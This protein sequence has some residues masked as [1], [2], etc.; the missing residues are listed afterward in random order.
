MKKEKIFPI[1]IKNVGVSINNKQE[2][3]NE[4]IIVNRNLKLQIEEKEKHAAELI[5]ANKELAFQNN[6]KEKRAAELVIANKELA[7][8]NDEKVKRAAELIVANIELAFQS[9]E[10]IKRTAELLIANKEL[11]SFTYISNHD[12]QEPL[13]KI[14]V[15]SS[16][17]IAEES[18]NLS[19][20]GLHYFERIQS[21]ALHMQTLIN[22]LLEYSRTKETKRKFEKVQL[23]K[24]VLDV[25]ES[26]KEKLEKKDAIVETSKLCEAYVIPFQF[27]Q[28]LH[29]LITNSL[30]FCLPD[31]QPHIIISSKYIYKKELVVK[32]ES[33]Q[34]EYCR[35]S[36]EDN[37][38]GFDPEFK[39]K[40]FDI[41]QRLHDPKIYEGTGIGLAIVKKIVDNHNG[42]ITAIGEVGKGATF[43]IYMP[44]DQD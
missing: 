24:I 33:L 6:E 23:N 13:R 21:S 22:D 20:K 12:L 26:L 19:K 38:I 10:R 16:L 14:Q 43:N 41:F 42:F 9:K 29:N 44:F 1:N 39:D 28:L 8:Q 25:I 32:N 35:I 5:V 3:N 15:F 17:I 37:G 7:F 4:L 40:I 34:I 18:N 11:Q 30:K 2:R 36:V 27:R 31:Q